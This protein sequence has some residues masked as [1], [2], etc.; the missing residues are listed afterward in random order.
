MIWIADWNRS[1]APINNQQS[2]IHGLRKR[3]KKRVRAALAADGRVGPMTWMDDRGVTKRKQ[4]VVDGS[5]ERL[6]IAAG[7]L[8]AA[9]STRKQRVA[10]EQIL[11]V[12]AAL[13]DL[14]ADAARTMSR[15]V[16]GPHLVR[17]ERNHLTRGV[18]HVD[19][20]RRLDV[21]AEQRACLGR[22][23]VDEQVVAMQIDRDAKSAPG[24]ADSGDMVDVRMRQQDVA[25]GQPV[26]FGVR[27]QAL[28][29]VSRIDVHGFARLFAGENE[30]VFHERR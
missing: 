2:A 13:P 27:Q 18:V 8:R 28:D 10:P 14:E 6:V 21:Y 7:K 24:G 19:G 23:F 1:M 20:R 16:V 9:D 25:D 29:L 5:H 22:A 4:D 12:L 3:T 17:A 26:P 15:R 11:T 30:A